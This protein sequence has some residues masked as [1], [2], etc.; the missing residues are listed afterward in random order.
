MNEAP[1]EAYLAARFPGYLLPEARRRGLPEAAA[2]RFL[3]RLGGG[4]AQLE[5]LRAASFAAR[6]A[7]AIEALALEALPDLLPR[8]PLGAEA[9]PRIWEGRLPGRPD[10]A[11]TLRCR[12]AGQPTRFVTRGRGAGGDRLEDAVVQSA[13]R[14]IRAALGA[15]AAAGLRG[16]GS[17]TQGTA[18]A[19]ALDRALASP[20]LASIPDAPIG[21]AEEDFALAAP[22]PAYPLAARLHRAA[23]EAQDG[24]DPAALARLVAEGALAPLQAS[25]RFELAVLLRLVEALE[26]GLAARAPGRFLLRRTAVLPGRREVAALEAPGGAR[27]RVFYNQAC[28]PSGPHELG[29]R[30]Y[31]GQQ[32]R[33]RPD[34]VLQVEAPRRSPRAAV[35][36]AKLSEDRGYLVEGWQQALLYRLEYAPALTGWPKV[37]LVTSTPIA[38]PPRREDEVIAV[39]WDGWVGEGIVDGLLEGL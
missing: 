23:R 18:C 37:V 36:E 2:A 20:A 3:E 24:R 1:W 34:M 27:L 4:P 10:V 7:G 25:T 31:L 30:R 15:L 6:H 11:A 32:A 26:A 16:V 5:L 9:A 21:A 33:L 19:E 12:F 35:V 14:R 39:G 29:A 17:F 13:A 28:L 22:H 38:A 8:L